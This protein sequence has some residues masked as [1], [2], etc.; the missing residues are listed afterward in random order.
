MTCL[1]DATVLGLVEG[2]L[3]AVTLAAVDEHIDSCASCR[4][5]VTLVAGTRSSGRVL[6]RGDTV[7]RYVIGDLL[8]SGAMGRVYSAWE[9]E[10]DRRVAI[11]VLIEDGTANRDRLL[12]EAQAMAR[13]N[14]PNVVTVHEVGTTDAGV[15]VA[16]EL[17]DGDSLRTWADAPRPWRDVVRVLVEVA[18]GLAAVH[19]AGVVHRDVKPDNTIVGADGRV[20][21]GDFGLA[22]SGARADGTALAVGTHT[23]VAGTPAYMAPEV[24]RGEPATAA[25][26]QFSFGV[27]AYELLSARRPFA[28]TTWAEL[29]ASIDRDDVK[30][31]TDVP[32]WLQVAVTRSLSADPARRWPSMQAIGDHLAREASK[33]RPTAWIAGALATA[34]L[35]SAATL[36]VAGSGSAAGTSCRAAAASLTFDPAHYTFLAAPARA[37]L[38]KWTAAWRTERV[39]TCRDAA[40]GS[41]TRQAA[42]EQ[43]LERRRTE[44]GALLAR[45]DAST[46]DRALDALSTLPPPADCRAATL[47][48]SDPLPLDPSLATAA[49]DVQAALPAVR[50]SI[51]LGVRGGAGQR[52]AGSAA[53]PGERGGEAEPTAGAAVAAG[54]LGGGA[55]PASGAAVAPGD[56]GG[57]LAAIDAL[58][59]RARSSGHAPTVADALLAQ[60]EALRAL[61]RYDDAD[62]AARDA[63]ASAIRGR[64]D[65]TGARAW[66]A[67]IAI[68][69]ERRELASTDDLGP[70]ADAAVERAGSPPFL[71][72]TLARLRG[73]VAYNRGDLAQA[74]TLLA[75]ALTRFTAL[76]GTLS[77]DVATI[78]SALGSVARAAGDL[79]EAERRH[80][81]ALSIDVALRGEAHRDVARDHHN[82]AGVLR[83]RGD[84]VAAEAEYRTALAIE[85]ATQGAE[86]V[87]AGLTHNSLGL[88]LM[89]ASSWPAAREE[90]EVALATLTAAGHGDRGFAEHNLGL[91]EQAL[92]HHAVALEHFDRAAQVYATTIGPTAPAAIRLTDD[93]RKS[94]LGGRTVHKAPRATSA[95]PLPGATAAMPRSGTTAATG[96]V[97]VEPPTPGPASVSR[98]VEPPP[99]VPAPPVVAPANP[100]KKPDVGV[101]GSSQTW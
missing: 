16:M 27:M 50:A 64:A 84:L 47:D 62:A 45:F 2:R 8:G 22:R 14:H 92:G 11:K 6:A 32:A 42:R 12:R 60:A 78:E 41:T 58:V 35:A 43:C 97:P 71:V 9:P 55:P 75:D 72:A 70:V 36:Y 86:S 63:V 49:R 17:V 96:R 95:T 28:G 40:S 13:L 38:D 53:A 21:L 10:L 93:R 7:G 4:D 87:A 90:L 69:G 30:P 99:Q 25:S 39:E 66:L 23:S 80:R 77:I 67:R 74:Y 81:S 24:L 85:V 82:I 91:V 88:V 18:R 26:D 33:Q 98:P 59:A 15:F 61:D 94:E 19:A 79:D 37:A 5:V 48:T 76:S 29:L 73:L 57:V 31:L 20:R 44:L 89:A 51:A 83:L 65:T 54:D 1:D 3:A 100:T 101:Y 56:R 46:A 34:V 52:A 68:A